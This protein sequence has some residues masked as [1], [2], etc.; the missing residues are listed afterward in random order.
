MARQGRSTLA[1]LAD[2]TSFPETLREVGATQRSKFPLRLPENCLDSIRPPV[3]ASCGPGRR[4][5]IIRMA[6]RV[7]AIPMSSSSHGYVTRLG[8]EVPARGQP[9]APKST[10]A[11]LRSIG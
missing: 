6:T 8:R 11:A 3:H 5:W 10:Y 4:P 1:V 2:A 7:A 9:P